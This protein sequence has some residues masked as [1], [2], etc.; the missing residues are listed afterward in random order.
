MN[1]TN[2]IWTYADNGAM[3]WDE[4]ATKLYIAIFVEG[5]KGLKYIVTN[6]IDC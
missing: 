4:V 2:Y 3:S 5:E 1:R 6:H